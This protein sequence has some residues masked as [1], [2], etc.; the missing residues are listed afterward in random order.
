MIDGMGGGIDILAID[1]VLE[2]EKV[3][4][5]NTIIY[6]C[7]YTDVANNTRNQWINLQL[8]AHHI[9]LRKSMSQ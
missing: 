5:K 6:K 1:K 4:D 9:I 3:Q 2:L 8:K 7:V